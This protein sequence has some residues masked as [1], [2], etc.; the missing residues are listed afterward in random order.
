MAHGIEC[1]NASGQ[2]TLSINRRLLRRHSFLS[3]SL[4][5]PNGTYLITVTGMAPDGAWA[6]FAAGGGV[7]FETGSASYTI[8]DGGIQLR[9]FTPTGTATSGTAYFLICRC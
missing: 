7:Q 1:W 4:S 9:L 2:K 3:Y 8:V 5:R 6:V